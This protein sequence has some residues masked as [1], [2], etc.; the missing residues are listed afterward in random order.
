M[1][2]NYQ[3]GNWFHTIE[4]AIKNWD[5]VLLGRRSR[6]NILRFAHQ[7]GT[8]PGFDSNQPNQIRIHVQNE[9]YTPNSFSIDRE[10][11]NSFIVHVRPNTFLRSAYLRQLFFGRV[12]YL[13]DADRLRNQFAYMTF[14]TSKIL[15]GIILDHEDFARAIERSSTKL[16]PP[17]KRRSFPPIH[18]EESFIAAILD[19][20]LTAFFCPTGRRLLKYLNYLQKNPREYVKIL[21]E[22]CVPGDVPFRTD[23][24]RIEEINQLIREKAFERSGWMKKLWPKLDIIIADCHGTFLQYLPRIRYYAGEI[25]IDFPG[26]MF[27]DWDGN[28]ELGLSFSPHRPL[29]LK[30]SAEYTLPN[31]GWSQYAGISEYYHDTRLLEANDNRIGYYFRIHNAMKNPHNLRDFIFVAYGGDLT[32]HDSSVG[33]HDKI[34]IYYELYSPN[35][36]DSHDISEW[37]RRTPRFVGCLQVSSGFFD[38]YDIR[39]RHLQQDL[40]DGY[41]VYPLVLEGEVTSPLR[42]NMV[43]R[44]NRDVEF[45][46]NANIHNLFRIAGQ[47]EL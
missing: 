2:A 38:S 17:A 9:D 4:Y 27:I 34:V 39:A 6:W 1:Y 46:T 44:M 22:G 36:E 37:V 43:S 7:I 5:L 8:V 35:D 42:L 15:T 26:H 28:M 18:F 3:I 31:I 16:Y 25:P 32:F 40:L 41:T 10:Q 30:H 11:L 33:D 20:E 47:I 23:Y 45:N 12:A 21:R 13:F 19:S 24:R 14:R 29:A